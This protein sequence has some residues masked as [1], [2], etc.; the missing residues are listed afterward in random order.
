MTIQKNITFGVSSKDN[1]QGLVLCLTSVLAGSTLPGKI[2]VRLEGTQLKTNDHYL[3]TVIEM[4]RFHGVEMSIQYTTSE[5]VRAARQWHL[6]SCTTKYLWMGDDDVFYKGRCLI[7]FCAAIVVLD[8]QPW[9]YFTGCK[10]DVV[11]RRG[12]TDFDTSFHPASELKPECAFNWP[13]NE[14][15]C[16][17]KFVPIITMDTG[18]SLI[19]MNAV[20]AYKLRFQLFEDSLNCGGEDT[21]FGLQCAK[22]KLPAYFVPSAQAM[23]FGQPNL[24]NFGEFAARGEMVLRVC[25]I[26]GYDKAPV[27]RALFPWLFKNRKAKYAKETEVRDG[28]K[29]RTVKS[30]V[31]PKG[32]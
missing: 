18:N 20:Q 23:H 27:E 28:Q 6:D 10:Y 2:A 29:I 3:D 15:D 24:T 12:Y 14:R 22:A 26:K 11:N 7:N 1:N 17:G 25:D 21:L 31:K 9:A 16:E 19:N 13:W 5:G 30:K 32:S 4:A 8:R